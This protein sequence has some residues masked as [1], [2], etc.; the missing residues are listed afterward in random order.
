MKR[1]N[2]QVYGTNNLINYLI[3]TIQEFKKQKTEWGKTKQN[4]NAEKQ[5]ENS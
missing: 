4:R 5:L 1:Q 2:N 3:Y